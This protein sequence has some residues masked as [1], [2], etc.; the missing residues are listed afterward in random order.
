MLIACLF[1]IPLIRFLLII[2]ILVVQW[3]I[4]EITAFGWTPTYDKDGIIEPMPAWRQRYW[5]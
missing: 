4:V 2:L 3:V 5:P 1:I